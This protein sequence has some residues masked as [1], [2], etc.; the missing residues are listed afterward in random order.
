[1]SLLLLSL[2]TF[3]LGLLLI[4]IP[5]YW[6]F[7][8]FSLNATGTREAAFV[9][10]ISA[11]GVAHS[12]TRSCSSG[13]LQKCG[14]DRT[15]SG[16]SNEGFMWSGCSDNI[17]FGVLFSKTFVDAREKKG[18][19]SSDRQLMNLHNNEAGRRVSHMDITMVIVRIKRQS[20]ECYSQILCG[21]SEEN[22]R[23]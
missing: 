15:V 14:C 13:D 3:C 1:M 19:V 9:H 11:A 16:A 7:S 2:I 21:G 23:F 18:R 10:A 5:L 12:V 6:H 8:V 4:W 22:F 17:A 20:L